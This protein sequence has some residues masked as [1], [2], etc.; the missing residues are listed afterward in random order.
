MDTIKAIETRSS[1]RSYATTPL[2]EKEV[3]R[4]VEAAQ[5]APKASA[6]HITVITSPELLKEINDK[7]LQAMQ[8]SGNDF[9][10]SRAALP[11]YM[12]L[13]GAPLLL[14]FSAPQESPFGIHTCACAATAA[15]IAATGMELGSCYVITPTLALTIDSELNGR[16]QLP[17]GFQG[18][19]GL[20][21]G[22]KDGEKYATPKSPLDNVTHLK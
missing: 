16:L 22:Y 14:L 2:S 12:P 13:H 15:A 9:L 17:A 10:V 3:G 5:S 8:L 21:A 6:F 7:A 19:C 20:L 1:V 18:V 11:G 4:L